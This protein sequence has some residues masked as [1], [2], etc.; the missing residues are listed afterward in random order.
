VVTLVLLD[1]LVL[2][3]SLA[4][5][6]WLKTHWLLVD[7]L[8]PVRQHIDLFLR[9]WPLLA[10]T[11]VF[12]GVYN[13]KQ[14]V[15]G[16]RPLLKRAVIGAAA[17]ACVWIAGTFYFKLSTLFSYSRVVFTLFLC[18]AAAGLVL[19][20]LALAT[21]RNHWWSRSERPRR[22]LIFGG[23]AL[24]SQI[25]DSLR[26]QIFV[27]VGTIESTGEVDLPGVCRLEEEAALAQ[28]RQGEVEQ[29]V[30]D[31]PPSRIKLL[32]RIAEAAY[33]EGV[34]LQI[35]PTVFAGMQMQPKVER[36]GDIPV[37]ELGGG[38]LPL[39][40][41]VAKRLM[42][43][44]LS[45]VGL[46]V[47][48]PFFLVIAI[49]IK[50]TSA[51]PVFYRQ[52]RVGMDG[53][54]FHMLKFR[55]MHVDAERETGPT[56]AVTD[57]PR[58]T[59]IGRFLRRTNIDEFPQLF[60]VLVGTMSLV[61][62]RPERP[63][64]VEQFKP[65][66]ERYSHKHWVRPGITGWAQVNGW[67]GR[68]DLNRRIEHDIYYIEHWSLWFDVKII[69]LT[70][71]MWI[72]GGHGHPTTSSAEMGEPAVVATEGPGTVDPQ[73]PEHLVGAPNRPDSA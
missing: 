47:L 3:G 42:D 55:T 27:P 56:W 53:R 28:I 7:P 2:V 69:F 26:N 35:T 41:V 12:S 66:I 18:L 8:L 70:L 37:V 44:V 50:L 34:P 39:S 16:L 57:D 13:L 24:G 19:T 45:V 6:L 29:I 1:Q 30:V 64:F 4:A 32:S 67:R 21:F 23:E 60:N 33:R 71:I 58:A 63:G 49:A 17:M 14:A 10:I 15:G 11:L 25:V 52:K 48:A 73:A 72:R 43:L 20:R 46:I 31:L 5:A 22:V 59:R 9:L 62:P 40:G 36:I 65:V 51:G 38:D 61:G 68:T 54:R